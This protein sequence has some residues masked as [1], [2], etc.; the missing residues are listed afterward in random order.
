[1]GWEYSGNLNGDG[2]LLYPPCIPSIRMKIIRDGLEDYGYLMEVKK[3]LPQ[4]KD[5]EQKK[6]AEDILAVP[7]QIMVDPHYFNRNPSGILG[8]REEIGNLI[9]SA[10]NNK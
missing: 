9:D 3:V 6:R 10:I 2:F 1:M 8:I 7:N 5:P 4:I